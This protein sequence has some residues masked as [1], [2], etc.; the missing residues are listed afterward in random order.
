MA[1]K[2]IT[3]ERLTLVSSKPFEDVVKTFEA[4]VGHPDM[5]E[6]DRMLEEAKTFGEMEPVVQKAVGSSGFMEFAHF[7]LGG[8]LSK[9]HSHTPRKNVRFV[10][11]NPL[12]MKEMTKY[13]PDAG[14]Y[15][16]VSILIDE[17]QDGVHLTYDTMTSLLA[18][19]GSAEALKVARDLDAKIERLLAQAAS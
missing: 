7:N 16:P 14:S 11:G 6:F 1:T 2:K 8:V 19:Y 9:D 15:A 5:K 10:V 17:R 18:P 12:I 3:V 4:A 13:V